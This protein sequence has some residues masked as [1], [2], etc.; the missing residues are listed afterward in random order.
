MVFIDPGVYSTVTDRSEYANLPGPTVFAVVGT[1][2]KGVFNKPIYCYG[3]AD[4]INKVGPP[5]TALPDYAVLAAIQ[6]MKRGQ[7]VIFVRVSDTTEVTSTKVVNDFYSNAV[8]TLTFDAYSAGTW[9]NSIKAGIELNAT[10][11]YVEVLA[12]SI[13]AA[14]LP[15]DT[16]GGAGVLVNPLHPPI[17]PGSFVITALVAASGF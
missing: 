13:N 15:Y 14:T 3:E 8:L 5:A 4:L 6:F 1:A 11:Q 2:T 9:G 10:T 16:F 12:T 17:L 7:K